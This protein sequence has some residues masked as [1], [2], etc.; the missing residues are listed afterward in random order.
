MKTCENKD[1]KFYHKDLIEEGL[2]DTEFENTGEEVEICKWC[3]RLA[4]YMK[5][6]TNENK[7]N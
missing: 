3:G 6:K 2:L 4:Y 7:K 5:E 1:C